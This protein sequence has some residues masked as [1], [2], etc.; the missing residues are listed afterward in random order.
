MAFEKRMKKRKQ[1]NALKK[2]RCLHFNLLPKKY[3]K[4]KKESNTYHL[5]F[6][7]APQTG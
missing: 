2:K 3:Q 6:I 7:I 4:S 1:V 5:I